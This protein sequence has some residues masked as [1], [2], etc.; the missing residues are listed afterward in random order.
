MRN[1]SEKKGWGSLS[2][3]DVGEVCLVTGGSGFV[4]RC[5]IER[6]LELGCKVK[7]FDLMMWEHKSVE[8]IKGDLTKYDQVFEAL[9]GV[10]TVFHVAAVIALSGKEQLMDRVNVEGTKNLIRGCKEQKVSKLIYTGTS[11]VSFTGEDILNA[12]EED[13][14][15]VEKLPK[16]GGFYYN[17]T[18]SVAES[19]VL[20][21]NSEQLLTCSIRPH[22]IYGP[23][24]GISWPNIIEKALV[25]LSPNH[26][27]F[28]LNKRK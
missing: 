9:K 13:T 25:I 6:L 17:R 21:A 24:D 18:K 8:F 5:M 23:G 19:L 27:S 7:N 11:S 15:D 26:F 16:Y 14:P 3:E 2:K 20:Q 1:E 12:K 22:S 4:G 28:S 10:N